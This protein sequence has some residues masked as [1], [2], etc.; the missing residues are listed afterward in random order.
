MDYFLWE[1]GFL[2]SWVT[3][4][5]VRKKGPIKDPRWLD[6]LLVPEKTPPRMLAIFLFEGGS[7]SG[8]SQWR[9]GDLETHLSLSLQEELMNS[10]MNWGRN[11][12]LPQFIFFFVRKLKTTKWF[13]IMSS[14]LN[15]ERV[16]S[17]EPLTIAYPFN[18]HL[19]VTVCFNLLKYFFLSQ[20]YVLFDSSLLFVE[21][22][23]LSLTKQMFC[24]TCFNILML[25]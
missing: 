24:Q 10:M 16:L 3:W 21:K 17:Y 23:T 19:I 12:S 15:P 22:I 11:Q 14:N 13:I 4:M 18:W 7:R 8:I 20:S 6:F 25:F 9:E 5:R 1:Q 2:E